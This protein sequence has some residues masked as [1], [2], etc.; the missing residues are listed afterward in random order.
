LPTAAGA[1]VG[2]GH[3]PRSRGFAPVKKF[4]KSNRFVK[5]AMSYNR[6]LECD[7]DGIACEKL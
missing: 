5:L 1:E 3:D 6:R 2:H 7:H 4:F